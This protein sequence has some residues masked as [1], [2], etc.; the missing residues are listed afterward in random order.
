MIKEMMQNKL[1]LPMYLSFWCKDLICQLLKT[2]PTK[3]LG[4]IR[5]GP[6]TIR[7]H[8]F[9]QGFNWEGLKEKTLPPPFVPKLSTGIFHSLNIR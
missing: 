6:E 2:N 9:F 8:S 3:R 4:V 5:G 1:H 7:K